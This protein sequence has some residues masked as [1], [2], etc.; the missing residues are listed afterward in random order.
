MGGVPNKN[1]ITGISK[2]H[3]DK[4]QVNG[5]K[6]K[7]SKRIYSKVFR[8]KGRNGWNFFEQAHDENY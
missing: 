6:V 1:W 5:K 4:P 8:Q 7:G 2:L 3:E